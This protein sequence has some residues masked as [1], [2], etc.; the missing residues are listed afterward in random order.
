[1]SVLDN[2]VGKEIATQL[3]ISEPTVS[4]HVAKI[5]EHLRQTIVQV[6]M[7]YSF[8]TEEEGEASTAGLSGNDTQFD[9]AVC[10][11]YH[12]HQLFLEQET[13]RD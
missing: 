6:V 3:G 7:Q 1:M 8:T 4:R 9:A 12:H 11:T 10:E 5:R 2:K 13:G